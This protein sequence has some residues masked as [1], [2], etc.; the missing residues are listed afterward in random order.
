MT[1]STL[2]RAIS[3]LVLAVS[4]IA[5][6]AVAQTS[7]EPVRITVSYG[8]L[9]IVHT[10]GATVLL[11]RLEAAARTACG[12][13]PDIRVL[14]D[15]AAFDQCRSSA[16]DRAVAEAHSPALTAVATKSGATVR[17]ARR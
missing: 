6:P 1:H 14:A 13:V 9:D 15:V 4:A 5:G 16:L 2:T 7:D 12:G 10:A 17:L 11:H 8:D 3:S